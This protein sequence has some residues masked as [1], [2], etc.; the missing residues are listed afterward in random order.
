MCWASLVV[1]WLRIYLAMQ[2]TLVRSL[3]WED[4]IYHGTHTHNTIE[5]VLQS[6]RTATT[7]P[8]TLQLLKPE[9]YRACALQQREATAKRSLHIAMQSS[10]CLPQLEKA[11]TK[12]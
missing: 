5:S 1:Q 4:P 7:E 11:C 3:V 10:P 12:Q 8:N 6:S 2:G 9:S